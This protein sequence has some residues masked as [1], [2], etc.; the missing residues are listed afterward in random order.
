[1]PQSVRAQRAVGSS[2]VGGSPT[3][4]KVRDSLTARL[5]EGRH[6]F[7]LQWITYN[8]TP[9]GSVRVWREGTA[10]RIAGEQRDAT[11]N[12]YVRLEGY[13][14]EIRARE[15]VVE[16]VLATRVASIYG[17]AECSR[18]GPFTFRRTGT[19]AFFRVKEMENP[20]DPVTDYVDLMLAPPSPTRKSP[21]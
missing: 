2:G 6:G 5:L 9:N 21:V 4:A 12:D 15:F 11:R 16:G 18:S 8:N 19:R 13:V 20:C 14:T 10:Y 7:R 17:G 3:V 1:M